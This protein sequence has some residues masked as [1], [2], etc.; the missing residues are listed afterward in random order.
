MAK[1]ELDMLHVTN[2][3]NTPKTVKWGG[4]AYTLQPGEKRIWQRFLAEHFAKHLTNDILLTKEADDKKAYLASGKSESDY[5]PKSYMNNKK[6]RPAVI[7]S[8]L[9]GVYSYHKPDATDQQTLIQ[10]QIDAVN[11]QQPQEKEIDL[12]EMVDPLYGAMKADDPEP[13]VP[14]PFEEPPDT[15]V[16]D[17]RSMQELRAEGDKLGI[18]FPIGTSKEQAIQMIRKEYA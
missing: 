2:P 8:I 10:Q 11:Q 16:G 6:M 3:T 1:N 9:V 13:V 15:P 7:D 4:V 17:G 12:G 18:K 5:K 14:A